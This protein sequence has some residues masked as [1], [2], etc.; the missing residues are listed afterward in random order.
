MSGASPDP[1]GGAADRVH[2]A[3]LR[4]C[5]TKLDLKT[6]AGRGKTAFSDPVWP[7]DCRARRN[8]SSRQP[9]AT[10]VARQ[11]RPKQPVREAAR[12]RPARVAAR[13]TS[14]QVARS[15]A[16]RAAFRAR[17]SV[18]KRKGSAPRE[19]R[20]PTGLSGD[21]KPRAPL[22]NKSSA[23]TKALSTISARCAETLP[24]AQSAARRGAGSRSTSP[25]CL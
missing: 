23:R 19:R 21:K 12:S 1:G 18:R 2:I 11:I 3:K 14:V 20:S 16:A 10:S 4:G 15:R 13:S 6:A 22:T 8:Q 9:P 7:P 24:H 25:S 5:C 17:R